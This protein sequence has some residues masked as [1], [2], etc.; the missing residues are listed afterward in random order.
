[1]RNGLLEKI[2]KMGEESLVHWIWMYLQRFRQSGNRMFEKGVEQVILNRAMIG[3][4]NLLTQSPH[5]NKWS[6]SL[7]IHSSLTSVL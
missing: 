4:T 5:D 1:M 3:R 7:V 6:I 2:R